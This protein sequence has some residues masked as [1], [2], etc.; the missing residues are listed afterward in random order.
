M[1]TDVTLES[2]LAARERVRPHVLD[3]PSLEHAALTERLGVR[4]VVKLELLQRCG[5]FK[6]RGAFNRLLTLAPDE[7]ARGVVAVSGGNHAIA[8]AYA[9]RTL[10]TPR[11][12]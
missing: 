9:A 8:V 12:S 5:M 10:G 1:L 7:L 6:V 11:P 4:T 2:V 3:T